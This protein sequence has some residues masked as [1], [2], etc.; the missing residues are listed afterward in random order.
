VPRPRET[1]AAVTSETTEVLDKKAA[2]DQFKRHLQERKGL[3]QL[4]DEARGRGYEPRD[5]PEETFAVRV[6]SRASADV[7]PPRGRAGEAVRE[8]EFELVGQSVSKGDT[9]GAIATCTVKAGKNEEIYEFFVE[10]PGGNFSQAREFTVEDGEVVEADSWWSAWTGCLGRDCASTCLG[11]L[12]ACTGTWAAYLW[13]VVAA[14]GGCVL[15]C[16]GCATCNC[17]WWCRWAVG[18]CSH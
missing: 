17:G 15:K 8:V 4:Q 5:D 16:T 2:H 12:V 1:P 9:E 3:K 14:C 7:R 18:C 6:K 10:A 13:C 11:A